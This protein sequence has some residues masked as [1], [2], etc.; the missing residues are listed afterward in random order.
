MVE[1]KKSLQALLVLGVLI[2]LRGISFVCACASVRS[3]FCA[4][5][6]VCLCVYVRAYVYV[7]VDAYVDVCVY[8]CVYMCI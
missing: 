6:S 4:C 5:V 8:V 2:C 7:Y 1:K 3:R